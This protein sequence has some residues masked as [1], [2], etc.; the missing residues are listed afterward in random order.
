[1]RAVGLRGRPD[2]TIMQSAVSKTGTEQ[3]LPHTLAVVWSEWDIR[4]KSPTWNE[5]VRF[6]V[7]CMSMRQSLNARV[8]RRVRDTRQIWNWSLS[9]SATVLTVLRSIQTL[10]TQDTS[11]PRHFGPR[12]FGTVDSRAPV[13]NFPQDTLALVPK[14]SGHFGTTL[15]KNSLAD[16]CRDPRSKN[17]NFRTKLL[18]KFQD[19]FVGFTR[20]KTQKMHVFLCSQILNQSSGSVLQ[21]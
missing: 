16:P 4:S 6:D 5:C 11:D 9:I 17:W 18:E 3:F 20:L 19:N 8:S 15:C 14:C 7:E 21:S 2:C 10:W 12:T 1:M 13:P